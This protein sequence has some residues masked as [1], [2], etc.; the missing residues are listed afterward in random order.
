MTR[1]T[2]IKPLDAISRQMIFSSRIIPIVF[3][4]LHVYLMMGRAE[5]TLMRSNTDWLTVE[6]PRHNVVRMS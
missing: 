5:H 1:R 6:R 4:P 3:F 2:M